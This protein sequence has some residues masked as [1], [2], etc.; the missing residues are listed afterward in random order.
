MS[1]PFEHYRLEN[2]LE[3]ILPR[4]T[5]SPVEQWPR[6]TPALHCAPF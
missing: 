1:I 6:R 5:S 2:G 3:V 4:D